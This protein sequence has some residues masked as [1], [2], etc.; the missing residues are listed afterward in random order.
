MYH[1]G[2]NE[3]A[4]QCAHQLS[5]C[6]NARQSTGTAE[7]PMVRAPA[8]LLSVPTP[9]GTGMSRCRGRMGMMVMAHFPCLRYFPHRIPLIPSLQCP[10]WALCSSVWGFPDVRTAGWVLT[11]GFTLVTSLHS[12]WLSVQTFSDV[13]IN[14]GPSFSSLR[15]RNNPHKHHSTSLQ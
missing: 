7:V 15:T 3:A 4:S 1:F 8:L 11:P 9:R 2:F 13:N 12:S 5:S 14:P 6:G 10:L